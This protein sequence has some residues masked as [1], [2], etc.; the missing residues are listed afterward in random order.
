MDNSGILWTRWIQIGDYGRM[1]SAYT[2]YIS[3]LILFGLNG[4]VSSKILMS[5]YEIVFFRTLI[6]S[7]F[8]ALVYFLFARRREQTVGEAANDAESGE[9]ENG[10]SG[11][12]RHSVSMKK[13]V[14]FVVLSGIVMGLSWIFLYEAYVRIGVGLSSITYYCGP[15]IVMLS[16]PLVFH[17]K[18][19]ASQYMCFVV[20]FAGI[21]LVSLPGVLGEGSVDV[22]GL[23]CGF[24]SAA[25]HALMVIFTM[26]APHITGVK[27]SMIQLA[28]SWVTV[29]LFL[30]AGK[31]VSLPDSPEQWFW[32]LFL[33]IVNTGIGCYLYFS[34]VSKLPVANVSILGY[35]EP[36]SS[37]IF[38]VIL[39][40]E[41]L[42]IPEIVGAVLIL[43]GAV[44]TTVNDQRMEKTEGNV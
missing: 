15:V 28:V 33:S 7:V 3:G 17:K 23:L 37:V 30:L 9:V 32:V 11:I 44:V 14:L 35:L 16:A 19:N 6:G 1:K 40:H 41:T 22:F 27:N 20:V 10:V 18:L 5:S 29:A 31:N 38:A 4:I 13:E 25:F 43:G 24:A 26:K 8:L 2:K 21:M 42:S 34:D 36:L 39:L 12:F